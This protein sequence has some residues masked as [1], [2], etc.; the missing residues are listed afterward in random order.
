M[1]RSANKVEAKVKYFREILSLSLRVCEVGIKAHCRKA[2]WKQLNHV[3]KKSN[4]ERMKR[5][6]NVERDYEAA[7]AE[8]YALPEYVFKSLFRVLF[9]QN[10]TQKT[11]WQN[12]SK[13]FQFSGFCIRAYNH[14]CRR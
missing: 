3:Q 12:F 9:S 10:F 6:G 1:K 13:N 14:T 4:K 11:F 8:I 5:G 7:I 2:M